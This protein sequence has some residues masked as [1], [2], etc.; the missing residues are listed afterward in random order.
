MKYKDIIQFEPINEV[1]Q[2]NLIKNGS[3]E[4]KTNYKKSLVSN[5]VF[6]DTYEMIIIPEICRNLDYTAGYET[7][8]LQIVGNYGTGKSHLMSLFSLV[9][10]DA[11]LLQLVK[12]ESAR[13]VLGNIAGR[14]MII[15]FELGSTDELW[16]IVCEQID[17]TIASWGM[18][19]SIAADNKG[20]YHD[21]L[22]RLMARFEESFPGKGLMIVIDEMLSYLK[23]RATDD[24]LNRDLAVLQ[25]LG[26]MSNH[27]KFR[28]VFGVQEL[29]YNTPQFQFAADMLGRVNDRFRQ[30]TITK[31]DVQFVV[32]QRMLYK[33]DDQRQTIRQHLSKFTG[34]FTDMH[35]NLDEYINLYP[36]HPAFFDNFQLI[37][38][39]KSQ[40]EVMKTLTK[41]FEALLD[42]DVPEDQPGLICYDH[43]WD[44][45]NVP[46]MK[47]EPDVRRVSEIMETIHQ[48]IDEN[49]TAARAKKA[50][51]A[52][53]IA[54]ACA[55][56]ILQ[57]SLE[58]TNGV[59]A[60][61]LVDDLCH[62][63]SSCMDRE[64]LM[65]TISTTAKQIVT[66][67][68]GQYF[69][70]NDTNQEYHLRV[71]GGVNYEQK[72]KDYISTMSEDKKDSHFFNFLVEHLPIDVEQ[73]RREFK[74]FRHRID[75]KSHKTMLD[76][77]IFMGNPSER[78]TTQ[79]QQNFYIY[80]MPIFNKS[81]IKIGDESDSI[82][83]CLDK[84]SDEMKE[85]LELYAAAEEQI[86]SVDSSQKPFYQQYKK[87]Y[88]EKLKPV[89]QHD[90]MQSTEIFYQ[91]EKQNVTPQMMTGGSKEQVISNIASTLLEDFFCEQLPDYP[92]FT[93]LRTPLTSENRTAMLKA[94]RQKIANPSMPSRDGEALLAG[95]GLMAENQLNIDGSIYAISIKNMLEKKGEGQ[96]LNRDEILH[97]FYKDWESDWR[98]NDYNI[99]AD[100]EFLVLSTMVALGA[101]EIDMPGGKNINAANLKEIVDLPRESFYSFSHVRRPKGM[102]VGAVREL[103]LGIVG[104][105][106]TSQLQNVEIY[107]DLVAKGKQI[108]ADAVKT[109]HEIGVGIYLGDIEVLPSNECMDIR[110]RLTA[111]SGLCD[112]LPSYASPAK[113]RN[114]PWTVEYLK[115]TFKAL[116]MMANAKKTLQFVKD[117][118]SRLSYLTQARQYMT[119]E[120][121][122]QR[123]D[124][125]LAKVKDIIA[126]MNDE[127]KVNDYQAELDSLMNEYADWYL[128]EYGRLHITGLQ[129]TDKRRI[130]NSNEKKVCD[131]VCGADHDTGYISVA[132]HYMEWIHKMGSLTVAS[133][134][135]TKESIL[136]S[137]YQAFN[138]VQYAGKSLP[139]L[140]GLKDEL[141]NIY[142]SVD[143][144]MHQILSDS[145][146]LENKDILDGSEQGLL[147]RFNARSEELSPMNADR[148]MAIVNKLHQGINKITTSLDALRVVFNRP[149]TPDDAVKAFR[150]H[151]TTITGGSRDANIRIILK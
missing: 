80:F 22:N 57:D 25:A 89:F 72:I 128:L 41:K 67:T 49:F 48:K 76:G 110:H 73:Y 15:R 8:G 37:R 122:K 66:A 108:A 135:V 86:A 62:L 146:L 106:M 64:F 109:S 50:P 2:F 91:G 149:M 40:R 30:I 34:Y 77:Y 130:M 1:V 107:A 71:E 127:Q 142:N 11:E 36:V 147:S 116:E 14:Y 32:Q 97:R 92:K 113:M 10:E 18:N 105:D 143:E 123:V 136:R 78:S 7:F 93:L 84:V 115:T 137:P 55:I 13:Q 20:M 121:M 125:A 3:E 129:D 46:A 4:D 61:N 145:T 101:I 12:S 112:K 88:E 79:P 131:I 94:A 47:T 58:K 39:G 126:V 68:V 29:I 70:K 98:T 82:Y 132:A 9:A 140:S 42:A 151:I 81:N 51:L 119:D 96:V 17:D 124:D 111:L 45:L 133:A 65:D 69:E 87:R 100:F 35:A 16:N 139:S 138:P 23:G 114:M 75:W 56:K 144:S 150:Q 60:E 134:S 59:S 141:Q 38:I 95:L 24:R 90:F 120:G 118:H 44:D 28:M 83:V 117:F 54:N 21:R 63:D 26:Q 99:D 53:R 102:N 148:L 43:Y 5:F 33:T 104:K 19:Y 103:F 27:S 52:H 6:S 74:I 85:L 31:Q